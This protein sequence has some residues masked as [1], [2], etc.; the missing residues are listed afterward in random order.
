MSTVKRE[1][2]TESDVDALPPGE[3]DYFD[4]PFL[5]PI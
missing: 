1:R 4:R 3:H 5:L 2:W